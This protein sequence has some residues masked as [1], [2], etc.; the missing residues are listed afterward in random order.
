MFSKKNVFLFEFYVCRKQFPIILLNRKNTYYKS[1][2]SSKIEESVN[3]QIKAEQQAGQDYLNIAVT[4]LH[5]SKSQFGAGAFFMKMYKE[6][7]DHMQKFINYQILRGGTPLIPGLEPPTPNKDLTLLDAFKQGL[8]M[9]KEIT[10]L[11]EN[12]VKLAE[13]LKDFH[14][15]DFVTSQFLTDQVKSINE[16]ATHITKLMAIGDNTHALYHYDLEL[17]RIHTQTRQ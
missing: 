11:L 4:F 9:E 16:M 1:N 12:G 7:L 13:E 3:K 15:A 2:Y 14:Y 17:E 8:C 5:P 10:V 6:E